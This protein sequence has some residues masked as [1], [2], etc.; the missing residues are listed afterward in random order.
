MSVSAAPHRGPIRVVW[1]LITATLLSS[2]SRPLSLLESR[3]PGVIG[4][5]RFWIAIG[6]F[7]VVDA[8]FDA[9]D[10][11]SLATAW[12]ARTAPA[13]PVASLLVVGALGWA[14][15]RLRNAQVRLQLGMLLV[16]LGGSLMPSAECSPRSSECSC[17]SHHQT[18]A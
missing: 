14:A 5:L 16:L 11:A 2:L 15:W 13:F 17:R 12:I 9:L 6:A 10:P 8:A 1:D 3:R 18:R 4:E 7:I